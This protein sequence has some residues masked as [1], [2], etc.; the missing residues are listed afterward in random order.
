LTPVNELLATMIAAL[1]RLA[2]PRLAPERRAAE[3]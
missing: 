1:E 3:A 2:A